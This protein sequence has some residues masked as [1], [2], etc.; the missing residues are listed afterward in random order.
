MITFLWEINHQ[1]AVPMV[2]YCLQKVDKQVDVVRW[3]RQHED[4]PK[5]SSSGS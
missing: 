2:S 1:G 5:A 3:D 4:F